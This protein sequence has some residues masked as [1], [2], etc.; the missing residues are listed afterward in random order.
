MR[1]LECQL[2]SRS[3]IDLNECEHFLKANPDQCEIDPKVESILLCECIASYS[4]AL[5]PYIS[6]DFMSAC[7]NVPICLFRESNKLFL[8]FEKLRALSLKRIC[9]FLHSKLFEKPEIC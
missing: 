1:I 4:M 7:V 3:E 5:F 2:R 9:L 6:Y 8:L